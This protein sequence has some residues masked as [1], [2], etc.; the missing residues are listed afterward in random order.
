MAGRCTVALVSGRE[1]RNLRPGMPLV[2]RPQ[3]QENKGAGC[4]SV[5]PC[6]Q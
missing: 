6:L 5:E 2:A 4:S 1:R 3:R